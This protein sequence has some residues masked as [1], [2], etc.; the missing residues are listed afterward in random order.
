MERSINSAVFE[1]STSRIF[2]V[3]MSCPSRSW[4]HAEKKGAIEMPSKRKNAGALNMELYAAWSDCRR[5]GTGC[6]QKESEI[7]TV[8]MESGTNARLVSPADAQC[9]DFLVKRAFRN[10]EAHCGRCDIAHFFLEDAL[11][12][13][14]FQFGECQFTVVV[15]I[16][17]LRMWFKQKILGV[18]DL[19]CGVQCGA[20]Q[21]ISQL[22]NVS[23]P[24]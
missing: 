21:N 3:A 5:H 16:G 4:E 8:F 9:F 15:S 11:N 22:A 10:S 13:H 12:V 6:L 24:G 18:Q 1:S 19:F 20:L 17:I 2:L 14:L 23:R 7:W